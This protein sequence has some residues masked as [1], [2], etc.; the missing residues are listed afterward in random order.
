MFIE[1]SNCVLDK[2]NSKLLKAVCAIIIVL[3]HIQI[4]FGVGG[5][6]KVFL[7]IGGYITGI[8]FFKLFIK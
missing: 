2:D 3:H 1:K 6:F 4:S 7:Y 5:F 8:F